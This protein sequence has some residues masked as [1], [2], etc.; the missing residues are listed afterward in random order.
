MNDMERPSYSDSDENEPPLASPQLSAVTEAL[1]AGAGLTPQQP[2]AL[3]Y[4]DEI[5]EG[6]GSAVQVRQSSKSANLPRLPSSRQRNLT[7]LRTDDR[8]SGEG[9]CNITLTGRTVS[10]QQPPKRRPKR[11]IPA[12]SSPGFPSLE[13]YN[14]SGSAPGREHQFDVAPAGGIG[15]TIESAPSDDLDLAPSSTGTQ[16]TEGARIG[17]GKSAS[18]AGAARKRLPTHYSKESPD[19]SP[20]ETSY[21][22]ANQSPPHYP[23]NAKQSPLPYRDKI[24]PRN[25]ATPAVR[26]ASAASKDRQQAHVFPASQTSAGIPPMAT[27]STA[28][29]AKRTV[30]VPGKRR[31]TRRFVVNGRPYT[32][33]RRLGKGGS[34]RVYEVISATNKVWALK[35]VPLK[36]LDERGKTLIRNEV[37][38]LES[39]NGADRVVHLV[40]WAIDEAKKAIHMVSL[41]VSY[42]FSTRSLTPEKVMEMGQIDLYNIICDH[43]EDNAKLDVVFVGYYWPEML[44]CV[45]LIHSLDIV[46]SDLKPANFV[47]VNSKLKLV[48]FGIANAIPDDTVNVY[49]DH[50]AGTP[51]YMAPETLKALSMPTSTQQGLSRSYRFG[52]PSDIWSLGCILHLMVYGRQPFGHIQGLAPKLMA[53]SDP[54]HAIECGTEGLGGVNVPSSY[55]RT[56]KACL[57]RDPSQRPTANSLLERADGLLEPEGRRGNVV[58]ATSQTMEGLF[59]NALRQA[60]VSASPAD[61]KSLASQVMDNLEEKAG[62][63]DE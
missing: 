51:N 60:G 6:E 35:T 48:D 63:R 21:Q 2:T 1:L 25:D 34:G 11:S 16:D 12:P 36:N 19:A 27:A 46:H 47:L 42:P 38:L 15:H 50:H 55:I 49:T 4:N 17:G 57:S 29:S 10:L 8:L 56:M 32:I 31:V 33:T 7:S 54:E 30:T 28:A 23:E 24:V 20:R 41:A 9:S 37:R 14:I 52:K 58:Y 62:G 40:D 18:T 26:E 61:I 39:L 3:P 5:D 43:Y 44:K 53:I 45:A 59:S 13:Q 22:I